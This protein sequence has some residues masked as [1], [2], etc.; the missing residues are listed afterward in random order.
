MFRKLTKASKVVVSVVGGIAKA[1]AI[2]AKN[3]KKIILTTNMGDLIRLLVS[4]ID[5]WRRAVALLIFLSIYV[6]AFVAT[7]S[8]WP[9][10]HVRR[11]LA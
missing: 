9:L 5:K 11:L 10:R 1:G 3:L 8:T 7:R 6:S 2:I 4:L